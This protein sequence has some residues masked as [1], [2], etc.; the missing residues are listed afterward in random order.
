M[1]NPCP[2]NLAGLSRLLL[3]LL[4]LQLPEGLGD[5]PVQTHSMPPLFVE[6]ASA[7]QTCRRSL[8]SN[9][10]PTRLQKAKFPWET[11][12]W[13]VQLSILQ[14]PAR[15]AV[16]EVLLGVCSALGRFLGSR[17]AVVLLGVRRVLLA[18]GLRLAAVHA[19]KSLRLAGVLLGKDWQVLHV[20]RLAL[21]HLWPVK[22]VNLEKSASQM[23]ARRPG[24]T[25]EV[26]RL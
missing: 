22:P 11:F 3:P 17:L 19:V 26:R 24:S 20:V 2:G 1:P 16:P 25:L 18:L 12:P 9:L 7:V 21:E 4:P 8:R 13:E 6:Q 5:G 10:G 14:K 15:L 23:S